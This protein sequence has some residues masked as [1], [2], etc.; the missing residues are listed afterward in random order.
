MFFGTL[1]LAEENNE[2]NFVTKNTIV[3][4]MQKLFYALFLFSCVGCNS[5]I[6]IKN[7]KTNES[8]ML[9]IGSIMNSNMNS[10]SYVQNRV[11]EMTSK[12]EVK[13]KIVNKI[14]IANEVLEIADNQSDYIEMLKVAIMREAGQTSPGGPFNTNDIEATNRLFLAKGKGNE[15]KESLKKYNEQIINVDSFV[16]TKFQNYVPIDLIVPYRK[17]EY[18]HSWEE[19]YFRNMTPISAICILTKFQNDVKNSEAL[20]IGVLASN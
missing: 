16:H 14:K 6:E 17:N 2:F 8:L 20:I 11:T 4:N 5:P 10:D 12:N 15:L 18:Q 19:G 9:I 3:K 1:K 7:K 13:H